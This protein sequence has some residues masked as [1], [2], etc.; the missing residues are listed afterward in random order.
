MR[1][2]TRM[3]GLRGTSR[4]RYATPELCRDAYDAARA[5]DRLILMG[6]LGSARRALWRLVEGRIAWRPIEEAPQDRTIL[7]AGI[8]AGIFAWIEP[9]CW[10]RMDSCWKV[11]REDADDGPVSPTHFREV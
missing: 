4:R 1:G 10:D 8:V 5:V 6:R 9:V 2:R 7:G 11:W 3:T